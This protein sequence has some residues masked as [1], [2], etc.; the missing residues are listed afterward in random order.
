MYYLPHVDTIKAA[1]AAP[2]VYLLTEPATVFKVGTGCTETTA[3]AFVHGREPLRFNK[4]Y[5]QCLIPGMTTVVNP[6]QTLDET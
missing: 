2:G 3:S 4:C 6:V 5:I 1:A